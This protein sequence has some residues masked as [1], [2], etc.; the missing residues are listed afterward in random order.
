M[1]FENIITH[2]NDHHGSN[3]VDLCV[4]FGG[5]KEVKNAKLVS[6][7][8]EGLDI[9]YND[10]EKL[11]VEFVK[12]ADENSLKDAI[13]EL[14]K[15]AKPSAN[16]DSVK[17]EMLE[18]M[19][20]FN[21]VCLATLSPSGSVVCSYAP[22]IQ[23]EEGNFIYISEVSEHFANIKEHPNNIEVMFLE[24]ESQAASVILRKRVR[25]KAVAKFM[26][27]DESF[28]RIYDIFEKRADKAVKM[29]RNMLDF[30]LIKL[31]FEEGRFVKGFGQAYNVK[32]G[33]LT[34]IGAG[35]GNPHQFPH[36]H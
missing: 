20:E 29:I 3:L 30:H 24:D 23:C 8:F 19:R 16:L 28:D 25:F 35:A 11:R 31:E 27:R 6:V 15:D 22:L 14:C 9:V 2:M 36:K 10:N 32:N 34:H 33:E 13:I 5:A 4:K 7:D 26:P 17:Q 12:K 21:S 18:F 1:N